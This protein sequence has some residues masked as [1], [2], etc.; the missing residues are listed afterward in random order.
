MDWELW[1]K[2][3]VALQKILALV[4]FLAVHYGLDLAADKWL[5]ALEPNMGFFKTYF[6]LVTFAAFGVVYLHILL[7]MVAVFFPGLAWIGYL[8]RTRRG[9][10]DESR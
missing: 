6:H 3:W 2:V 9:A 10:K 4:I 1:T 8:L 7:E 5:F